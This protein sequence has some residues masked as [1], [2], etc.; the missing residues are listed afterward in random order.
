MTLPQFDELPFN[1]RPDLTPYII[2]LTKSTAAEDEFSAYKNLVSILMSG[3]IWGSNSSKGFIKGPNKATCFMDVPFSALKHVLTPENANPLN[4]RYEPYGIV[5]TKRW[6]Y[7]KK[8]CRP[9]LYLSN[10]ETTALHI[11]ESEYWRVVRFELTEKGWISWVHEREWRCKGSL[12][13]PPAIQAV[14]V[15]NSIEASKLARLIAKKPDTF[16]CTPRSIIPLTV[17]SQGL[18]CP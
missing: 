6:A 17:I 16:K 5:L 8:G 18:L 7:Q 9:V 1:S 10:E 11:P 12:T 4:P 2:H 14:L 15:K 13:L 3:E